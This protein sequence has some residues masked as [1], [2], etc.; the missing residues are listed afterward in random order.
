MAGIGWN[1]IFFKAG[2][3]RKK[4]WNYWNRLKIAENNCVGYAWKWLKMAK[5]AEKIWKWL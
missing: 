2:K 3:K 1:N 5:I 4:G